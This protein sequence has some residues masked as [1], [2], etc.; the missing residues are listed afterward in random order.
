MR[1]LRWT[2]WMV[3]ILLCVP[4]SRGDDPIGRISLGASGGFS[5]YALGK[6]N[7]RIE[8]QGNNW[9]EEKDWHELDPLKHGWTFW[10]DLKV[11]VPLD[12]VGVREVL[13]IP[14][15]FYLSGG[16]GVSSGTSGG[17]DYNELI[18][19]K[20]E[21]TAVHGRLLYVLPWRFQED[22]R[23]FVGGGPLFIS[24]QKV[25]ATHTSRRS[26]GVGQTT[27][28][29]RRM[30]EVYY[31]GD[32][33]GFLAG[34]AMEYLMSDRL[35]LSIDLGYR[36]AKVDYGTWGSRQNMTIEDSDVV[37]FTSD[38]TTSLVR[39]RRDSSYVLHGFLDEEATSRAEEPTPH[40]YGPH[41]DQLAPLSRDDLNIDLTGAQIHVG[42]RVYVL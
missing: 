4:G 19:V 5:T 39:L 31:K 41:L 13:G 24:E 29:T 10:A 32:G 17:Q 26:A 37:V 12:L 20:G 1:V 36:W 22:T 33:T 27:Q 7:D 8:T 3:A 34:V 28:E 42:F 38:Q 16:Y 18:E 35:T 6:V 23:I 25:T 30:E 2:W 11:P 21:Q 14:L 15:D 40:T 9:L